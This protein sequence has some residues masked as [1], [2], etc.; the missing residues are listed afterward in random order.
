MKETIGFTCQQHLAAF[1]TTLLTAICRF[2]NWCCRKNYFKWQKW[3][4]CVPSNRGFFTHRISSKIITFAAIALKQCF[5][6]WASVIHSTSQFLSF[7][8]YLAQLIHTL[9]KFHCL[10]YEL[11]PTNHHSSQEH[12][13]YGT[14]CL[15]LVS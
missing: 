4:I 7:C 2:S 6:F 1:V 14:S 12:A 10:L 5:T 15:R 8:K 13:I 3:F 11:Y 9:S